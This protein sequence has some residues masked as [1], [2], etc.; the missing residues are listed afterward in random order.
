MSS[1]EHCYRCSALIGENVDECGI[2]EAYC[3]GA[4]IERLAIAAELEAHDLPVL[5]ELIRSRSG[6][7]KLQEQ[8][9]YRHPHGGRCIGARDH[10]GE[11]FP[12]PPWID[13]VFV[14]RR[15]SQSLLKRDDNTEVCGF[16][17]CGKTRETHEAE[18][19][20]KNLCGACRLKGAILGCAICAE[21][22]GDSNAKRR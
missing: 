9:L 2:C 13:H 7:A 10:K 16:P 12:R 1:L 21:L 15:F 20:Q 5:A 18:E 19:A 22:K 6:P 17:G 3:R 4:N 14:P 11:H 8:C